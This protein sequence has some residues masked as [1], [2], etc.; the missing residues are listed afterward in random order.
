LAI[1]DPP[2]LHPVNELPGGADPDDFRPGSQLAFVFDPT[3]KDGSHVR[4]LSFIF[5]E[6]GPGESVPLHRHSTD[7]AIVLDEGVAEVVLGGG[8]SKRP[9]EEPP[10]QCRAPELRAAHLCRAS[11]PNQRAAD[12]AVWTGCWNSWRG[13]LTAAATKHTLT[14]VGICE[15]KAVINSFL[16]GIHGCLGVHRDDWERKS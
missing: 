3:A 5:E 12:T 13:F 10:L 6:C 4:S 7:E 15:L 2:E 14:R 8:T 16:G 1:V 9:A 11:N